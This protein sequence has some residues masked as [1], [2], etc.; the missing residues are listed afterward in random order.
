MTNKM[1]LNSNQVDQPAT[2]EHSD[3]EADFEGSE[4]EDRPIW[5]KTRKTKR[6][7]KSYLDLSQ[8]VDIFPDSPKQFCELAETTSAFALEVLAMVP[9]TST[10]QLCQ[11]LSCLIQRK[12]VV[13]PSA[14]VGLQ[15]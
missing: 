5:T 13:L 6:R 2:S 4:S 1:E 3:S 15:E 10:V 14:Q 12:L 8:V 9:G 7:R 11:F